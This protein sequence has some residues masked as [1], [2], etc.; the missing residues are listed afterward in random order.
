MK[1][2]ITGITGQAGSHLAELL[3]KDGVEVVG[4]VRRSSAPNYW[5]LEKFIGRLR[6]IE[7]DIL[8]LSS[9]IP[10]LSAES[11]DYIFNAAAQSHVHT[12]FSQP[13]HTFDVTAVG[14]L[15]MLEAMKI[16]ESK[17]HFVQF[18]SSEMFGDKYSVVDG[19]KFQDEN[20]QFNPR[21]PY[22]IAKLAAYNS[23]R[24]YR[25]AYNLKASNAI[26]FNMEGPRRG[27]NFVTRKITKYVAQL[28]CFVKRFKDVTKVSEA[29][30]S[31]PKLKLG[32]INSQRDWSYCG[33]SMRAVYLMAK[34]PAADDYV[35]C[36]EQTHYVY[37][38]LDL[39]FSCIGVLEWRKFV[40]IDKELLRPAEVPFLRG[41]ASKIKNKLGWQSKMSFANLVK[42]MV[43]EDIRAIS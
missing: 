7:G 4:L 21:S 23:T 31:Y 13:I 30:A 27:E 33:D 16:L 17:A 43:E 1:A 39:A 15:N 32:N 40:E 12:S 8:D 3:L 36:S 10:I 14:C 35:V 26:L 37:E 5:R 24:L 29:L 38:F 22:A 41:N 20:T 11:P 9:L 28:G 18:S 42:T 34:Q 6:L 25:S 2:F 19:F